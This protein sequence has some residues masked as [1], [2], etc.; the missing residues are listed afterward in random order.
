METKLHC[1]LLKQALLPRLVQVLEG[2]KAGDS[3]VTSGQLGTPEDGS[4]IS[5]NQ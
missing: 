3:V 1:A 2:L 5:I 4:A